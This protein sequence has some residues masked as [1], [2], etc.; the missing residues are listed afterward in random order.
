VVLE[1]YYTP[2][3]SG[4]SDS[5][6]AAK[7]QSIYSSRGPSVSVDRLT[8]IKGSAGRPEGLSRSRDR[9]HKTERVRGNLKGGRWRVAKI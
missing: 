5:I 8:D 3:V 1:Y 6:H 9:R 7:T 2:I 4:H